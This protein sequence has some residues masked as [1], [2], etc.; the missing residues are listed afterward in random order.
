MNILSQKKYCMIF[1]TVLILSLI[2]FNFLYAQGDAMAKYPEKPISLIVPFSAGG[3]HDITARLIVSV[4]PQY[5]DNNPMIVVLKPGASGA[6]GAKYVAES[7]PDGYTLLLGGQGPNSS[8]PIAVD[9]GYS[10]KDFI[11]IA[12][13]NNTDK[14]ILAV[15]PDSPFNT[16][17]DLIEY[18]KENPGKLTYGSS[19]LWGQVHLP[20]AALLDL[21]GVEAVHVPYDGGGPLSI[22]AISGEVDFSL[23]SATRRLGLIKAGKLKP[24]AIIG[25]ETLPQLPD[26]KSTTQLGYDF[27]FYPGYRTIFAPAGTPQERIDYLRDAVRKLVVDKSFVKMVQK[28]G[29]TVDY[30]DGP[31]FQQQ[32]EEE[33]GSLEKLIPKL[34]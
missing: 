27:P 9:V 26:V 11:P 8:L 13:I 17:D 28:L 2:F 24:L 31:E 33:I 29:A 10:Y 14:I 23:A 5:M 12:K 18:G 25:D 32:W 30:V 34:Q 3:T 16:L 7:K 4:L 6:I 1:C 22:A 21:T 15:H 19:G 20:T